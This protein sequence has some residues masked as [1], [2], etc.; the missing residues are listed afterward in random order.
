MDENADM[1]HL[2]TVE[3][4]C[5]PIRD[6]EPKKLASELSGVREI[7]RRFSL[8]GLKQEMDRVKQ[9]EDLTDLLIPFLPALD[10]IALQEWLLDL[11]EWGPLRA[12]ELLLDADAQMDPPRPEKDGKYHVYHTALIRAAQGGRIDVAK[13]LIDRGCDVHA[14]D[15]YNE[16]ALFRAVQQGEWK[17]P[18]IV[19][20]LC[21]RGLDPNHQNDSGDTVLHTL[22][23]YP[24]Q[25]GEGVA[26]GIAIT[27][28][29]YG[30]RLDIPN[31]RDVTPIGK[32]VM[33]G[34]G[35]WPGKIVSSV[36]KKE[37]DANTPVLQAKRGSHRL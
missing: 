29:K 2:P 6:R 26:L 14:R 37:L 1:L 17:A 24:T 3:A 25:E 30:A 13:L 32:M 34:R 19:A 7:D 22:V 16:T 9:T 10:A 36:Q 18:G 15:Q 33:S 20:F 8:A 35:S 27:L 4:L 5:A 12:V 23:E 31:K 21:E 28:V 11:S